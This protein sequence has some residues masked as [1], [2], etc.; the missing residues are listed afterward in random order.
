MTAKSGTRHLGVRARRKA[1]WSGGG[2]LTGEPFTGKRR[3]ALANQV[4]QPGGSRA[5]E[6]SLASQAAVR[7]EPAKRCLGA[8][9][10]ARG[11]FDSGQ[12]STSSDDVGARG[13]DGPGGPERGSPPSL[14]AHA[15]RSQ[16]RGDCGAFMC[17]GG[18]AGT[19]SSEAGVREER[20]HLAA[21]QPARTALGREELPHRTMVRGS[22]AR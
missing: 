22:A 21:V 9:E 11:W 20:R 4:K 17:R 14:R 5:S 15:W 8:T 6:P 7:L 16:A 10:G 2:L 13:V 3:R 1:L 18:S 19:G 12:G